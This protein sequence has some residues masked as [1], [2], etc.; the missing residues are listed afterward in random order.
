MNQVFANVCVCTQHSS[1]TNRGLGPLMRVREFSASEFIHGLFISKKLF[2]NKITAASDRPKELP[3]RNEDG[4]T[5]PRCQF[6]AALTCWDVSWG[7]Q[8]LEQ[9]IHMDQICL[10]TQAG[11]GAQ[12]ESLETQQGQ[13]SGKGKVQKSFLASV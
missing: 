6:L 5:A 8:V 10:L 3:T 13:N 11:F 12:K 7:H 2:I 4:S 1:D 9:P